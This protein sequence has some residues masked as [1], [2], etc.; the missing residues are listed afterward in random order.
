[1]TDTIKTIKV[2]SWAKNASLSDFIEINECDFDE[3]R[4]EL[5]EDEK[6]KAKK[7]KK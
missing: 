4:H 7:A 2:K 5:F 3:K 6:P 1:M